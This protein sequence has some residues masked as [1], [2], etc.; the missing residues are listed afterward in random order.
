MSATVESYADRILRPHKTSSGEDR[1][2][3]N[4]FALNHGVRPTWWTPDLSG[5]A[6]GVIGVIENVGWPIR[7]S[8]VVTS[9]SI[10]ILSSEDRAEISYDK[11][12]SF[13][14]L[15]KSPVPAE[16]VILLDSGMEVRVPVV[17]RD[18]GAIFTVLRFLVDA[19]RAVRLLARRG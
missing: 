3:Q 11:I 16:I 14:P 18:E 19:R 15:T 6:H 13:A 7:P 17:G 10:V 8:L 5:G 1:G 9:E 4:Y 2:L 12:H